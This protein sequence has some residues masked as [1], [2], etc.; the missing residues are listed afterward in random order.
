MSALILSSNSAALT[1][2]LPR[3]VLICPGRDGACPVSAMLVGRE[4]TLALRMKR[5]KTVSVT[6]AIG[7]RTV[8][9]ATQTVP[10]RTSADTHACSG[11]AWVI[12]LS[13][14]LRISLE[15][16]NLDGALQ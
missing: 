13:Q 4:K 5:R 8:A 3:E 15:F 11:M 1:H 2:P 10:M 6:P 14:D 12:G 9:G 7:A 16:P